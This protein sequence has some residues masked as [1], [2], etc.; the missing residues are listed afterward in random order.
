LA[1]LI[2]ILNFTKN[3]L[4]LQACAPTLTEMT[5]SAY[6]SFRSAV[7]VAEGLA[8][9]PHL[10]RL[11]AP[12]GTLAVMPAGDSAFPRLQHL[13]QT[14]GQGDGAPGEEPFSS[15][16]DLALWGLM[17]RG[18]VPALSSLQ[19]EGYMWE[20]GSE[21][22]H[23]MVAAFEG[24]A[25]TLKDLTLHYPLRDEGFDA[26]QEDGVLLQIGEAIGRLRLLET[27]DLKV[28]G[29]GH[30]YHLIGR[31]MGAA[32]GSCP[33]LR[34]LTCSIEEGA[35]WLACRPSI[36]VPS[37]QKL[38]VSF[39]SEDTKSAEPLALAGALTSL[40]FGG[41]VG[42]SGVPRKGAQRKRICELLEP[43]VAKVWFW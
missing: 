32:Q 41:S 29:Q 20:W 37:V 1:V 17:A 7:E 31:G 24:V 16:S 8:G 25:P 26:A 28:G 11:T 14:Y 34:S 2:C 35:A 43:R 10:E 27:L 22:G 15:L 33:L 5:L 13:H 21:L 6:S 40:D 12:V 9:C 3:I 4:L 42:L 36:I 39:V 18:G 19:L 30:A 38:V 23:V